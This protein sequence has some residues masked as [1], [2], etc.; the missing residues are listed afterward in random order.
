MRKMLQYLFGRTLRERLPRLPHTLADSFDPMELDPDI[1]LVLMTGIVRD[2][3]EARKL[4]EKHGAK[5]GAELLRKLPPPPRV[6]WRGRL[7]NTIRQWEGSYATDPLKEELRQW[8]QKES[9]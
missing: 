8:K 9:I 4:M 6:D 5:N 3:H 1:Q 7:Q 2:V